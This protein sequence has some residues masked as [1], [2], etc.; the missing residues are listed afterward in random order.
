MPKDIY[1]LYV[2]VQNER[3]RLRTNKNHTADI[4]ALTKGFFSGLN[5]GLNY[6][7]AKNPENGVVLVFLADGHINSFT[8]NLKMAN[9]LMPKDKLFTADMFV[10]L[11]FR[12]SDSHDF[13]EKG[14]RWGFVYVLDLYRVFQD[15]NSVVAPRMT[16]DHIK[17]VIKMLELL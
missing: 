11:H 14:I 1:D 6:V 12:I 5:L 8:E 15:L 3:I 7:E 2:S 17:T 16:A 9:S 13:Y 10:G 4:D